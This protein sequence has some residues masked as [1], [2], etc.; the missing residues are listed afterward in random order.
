MAKGQIMN[1][2]HD[3]HHC[4][5]KA[6]EAAVSIC[7]KN[8]LR[9]TKIRRRVLQLVWDNHEAIKAYDILELLQKDDS[10][11]KPP[12]AYRALDFLLEH[13]FIHRIESL[14]AYIGCPQPEHTHHFQL[15]ICNQC[16]LVKEMDKPELASSLEKY[17]QEAEFS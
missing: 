14:N 11:A 3:H 7:D 12:T 6:M 13:G 4:I 8:G 9:F 2:H 5:E 16:G 15:L 17:A 1:N 10:S